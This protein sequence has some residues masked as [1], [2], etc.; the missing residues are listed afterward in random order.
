LIA[1]LARL[2]GVR[3]VA[4]SSSFQFKGKAV[5]VREAGRL[6]NAG[7]VLEGSVRLGGDR[8]RVTAQL[9]EA[10]AGLSLWSS[11]F[12]RA[13]GDM[14]EIQC[15]VSRAILAALH[16]ELGYAVTPPQQVT[17]PE[18]HRLCLEGR[19]HWSSFSLDGARKSVTCFERAVVL[20]SRCAR[21]WTGLGEALSFL[22]F[23][24]ISP[25]ANLRRAREANLTALTLDD[26][27]P[28]AEA[29][30]GLMLAVH[31]WNW[32]EAERRFRR[33]LELSPGYAEGHYL[34]GMACLAPQGR[35]E[36]AARRIGIAAELDPLACR[37]LCDLGRV[38]LAQ[39]DIAAASACFQ[40][41]LE[42]DS[43]F[44]EAHWQLG[45]LQVETGEYEAALASFARSLTE[46]ENTPAVCGT[47]GHCYALMG[48]DADAECML[49][50]LEEAPPESRSVNVVARALIHTGFGDNP[51][52]LECL[53]EAF[54]LRSARLTWIRL[55]L[56]F[57][58]L[59]EEARFLA[60][61]EAMGLS[62]S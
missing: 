30:Y 58:P 8:L 13:T 46:S 42:I 14:F 32:R 51:G 60:I 27:L 49:R 21:A 9:V 61:L 18:V 39:G 23:R 16:V 56:R 54:R 26:R 4:R 59:Y 55:D 43:A 34:Y 12:E 35:F 25:A 62:V 57:R 37:V 3:V 1:E 44:R 47:L 10:E 52:A 2:R 11:T 31:D 33:A 28:D 24:G 5:D 17:D 19:H 22:A 41:A 7:M 53:E 50:R 48:R 29:N 15:G 6:L 36:E 20:D 40:H 38:R 45:L